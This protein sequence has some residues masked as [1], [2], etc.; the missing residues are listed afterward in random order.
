MFDLS[1][2]LATKNEEK[3]LINF[4]SF[5]N[6]KKDNIEIIIVDNNSTDK[7]LEIASRYLK[8]KN[9]ITLNNIKNY[10]N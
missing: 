1:I 6:K 3:N 4:F 2:I 10:L 7:T 8:K 5:L 9:I